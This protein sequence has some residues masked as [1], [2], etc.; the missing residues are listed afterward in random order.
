MLKGYKFAL[1]TVQTVYQI[2]RI[3][4]QEGTEGDVTSYPTPDE[5]WELTFGEQDKLQPIS[6][7]LV[8]KN[9]CPFHSKTEAEHWQTTILS[10]KCNNQSFRSYFVITNLVFY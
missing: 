9:Y 2:Y 5:L 1:H 6:A 3:D 7:V 4:M 8:V 10:G